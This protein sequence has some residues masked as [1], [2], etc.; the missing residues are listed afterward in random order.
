MQSVYNEEGKGLKA[1]FAVFRRV[2]IGKKVQ[3]AWAMERHVFLKV[4]P[5][6]NGIER[7][8][9]GQMG[10]EQKKRTCQHFVFTASLL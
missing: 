9:D 8:T 2:A 5:H 3:A 6:L 4:T 10:R 1:V 7:D